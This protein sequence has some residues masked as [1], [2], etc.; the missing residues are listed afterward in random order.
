MSF[1]RRLS[2]PKLKVQRYLQDPSHC[3][4]ASCA[5]IG[6][7]YNK[8][9]DYE[10]TKEVAQK[11]FKDTGEGLFS[12]E[13]GRLL[14]TLGFENVLF[15]NMDL[16]IFDCSW[17]KLNKKQLCEMLV[18]VKRRK[19]EQRDQTK[20]ILKFL[21]HKGNSIILDYHFAQY[22]TEY[23]NKGCPLISCFNWTKFFDFV[24]ISDK[25]EYDS[26][27]GDVEYHAVVVCGYNDKGV[28]IVDSHN[29]CYKYKLKKF[30]QGEYCMPW[31]D[32]IAV[33]T[34]LVIPYGYQEELCSY[35]LV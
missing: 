18:K 2:M 29:D 4:I 17:A 16:Q 11:M 28:F 34:D 12:T 25:G 7:F 27:K 15:V 32:Y 14:N 6:N 26:L 30:R 9:I 22:V 8:K 3:G 23:I 24:K 31:E 21:E 19:E 10:K 20:D 1:V 33:T 5:T 35:A 13:M